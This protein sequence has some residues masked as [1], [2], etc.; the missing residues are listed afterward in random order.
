[1]FFYMP[2]KRWSNAGFC[3]LVYNE[4]RE[5]VAAKCALHHFRHLGRV[6]ELYSHEDIV[7]NPSVVPHMR[8]HRP[9]HAANLPPFRDEAED[10]RVLKENLDEYELN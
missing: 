7:A 3:V 4:L 2:L 1:M 9:E 5:A 8:Q 10:R 6:W